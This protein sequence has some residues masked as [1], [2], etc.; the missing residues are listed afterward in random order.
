MPKTGL[1]GPL[2]QSKI[3]VLYLNHGKFNN[4]DDILHLGSKISTPCFAQNAINSHV[5]QIPI[6]V[7]NIYNKKDSN[8]RY[9][10]PAW[11]N[12]IAYYRQ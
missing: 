5:D 11:H 8:S 1:S 12:W 7:D 3:L 4:T 9:C 6:E 2:L 10:G